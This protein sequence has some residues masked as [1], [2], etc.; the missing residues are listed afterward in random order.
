MLAQVNHPNIIKIHGCAITTETLDPS[1]PRDKYF[2]IVDKLYLTLD[3][4]IEQ[5]KMQAQRLNR[6]LF[7]KLFDRQG[8]KRQRLLVE[9]LQVASEIASAF[10]YLHERRII[11]RDLKPSNVGFDEHG[12]CQ[13]FDF[14]L[15]R[16]LPDTPSDDLDDTYQMSGKVGTYRFEAAEVCTARAYNEK[17]DVYGFSHLLWMMLAFQK[18]Y[19]DY[20]KHTHRM[21]VARCG[22]RPPIDNAWPPPIQELLK[23]A[24][25]PKISERPSM[26]EVNAILKE[27]IS[28]LTGSSCCDTS[29]VSTDDSVEVVGHIATAANKNPETTGSTPRVISF[30][31]LQSIGQ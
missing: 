8:L 26:R 12:T 3:D 18:P 4:R 5:W 20:S 9:R 28:D 27:L 25:S 29:T 19:P 21:K 30:Y 24:W 22:E 31:D 23:R 17:V 15:A 14:G 2:L 1:S 6:P 7:R 16:P 13:I 11:Y 10:E